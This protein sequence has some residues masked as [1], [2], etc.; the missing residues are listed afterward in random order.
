M[1]RLCLSAVYSLQ[2]NVSEHASDKTARLREGNAIYLRAVC[3]HHFPPAVICCHFDT[4]VRYHLA[5]VSMTS[6]LADLQ[7]LPVPEGTVIAEYVW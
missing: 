5:R 2:G 1:D 6:S 4:A 3:V 7:K